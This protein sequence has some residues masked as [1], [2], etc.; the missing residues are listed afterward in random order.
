MHVSRIKE[1]EEMGATVV[2][3]MDISGADPLGALRTYGDHVLPK[4]RE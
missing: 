4:L 2:V 1:I 3:L